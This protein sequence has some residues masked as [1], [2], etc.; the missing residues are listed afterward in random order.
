V[1]CR[2]CYREVAVYY[3]DLA[4]TKSEFVRMTDGYLLDF[5]AEAVW[6]SLVKL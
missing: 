5:V 2:K 3:G 4:R 1:A 6:V